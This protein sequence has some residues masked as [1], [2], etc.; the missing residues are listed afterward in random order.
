[1]C[2][3]VCF[4]L[5]LICHPSFLLFFSLLKLLFYFSLSLFLVLGH[6]LPSLSLFSFRFASASISQYLNTLSQ[7]LAF[8]FAPIISRGPSSFLY[9][10]SLSHLSFYYACTTSLYCLYDVLPA[11]L[12]QL[13]ECSRN[14]FS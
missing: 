9:C 5:E 1:M 3:C 11:C 6:A 14:F 12:T 4:S 7:S 8:R 2:V 13:L 10:D